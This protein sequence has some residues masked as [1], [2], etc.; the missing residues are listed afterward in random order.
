MKE[1]I[2]LA[3]SRLFPGRSPM[4]MTRRF[5][6]A[7]LLVLAL[8]VVLG[9]P[10]PASAGKVKGWQVTLY[11]AVGSPFLNASGQ[12]SLSPDYGVYSLLNSF[13]VSRLAPNTSYHIPLYLKVWHVDE[14][15][16]PYWSGEWRLVRCGF[17]TD[18]RGACKSGNVPGAL[19]WVLSGQVQVYDSSTGTLVLTYP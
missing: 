3:S 5:A 12:A 11:P 8:A 17:Q 14:H 4:K 10:A 15:G 1:L 7:S 18:A 13:S 19:G 6:V 9:A 16:Y 2:V